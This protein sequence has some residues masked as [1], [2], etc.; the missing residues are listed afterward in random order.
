MSCK[1]GRMFSYTKQINKQ[2]K[3]QISFCDEEVN[4]DLVEEEETIHLT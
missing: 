4:E 3:H 1:K 2:I